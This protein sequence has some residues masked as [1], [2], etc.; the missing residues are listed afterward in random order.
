MEHLKINNIMAIRTIKSNRPES[1]YVKAT[2]NKKCAILK[3]QSQMF[4]EKNGF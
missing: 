1:M 4:G 2:Y 3:V